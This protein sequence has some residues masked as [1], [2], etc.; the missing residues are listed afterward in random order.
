[1]TTKFGTKGQRSSCFG[2]ALW[3]PNLVGRTPKRSE[4][5]CWL[6]LIFELNVWNMYVCM[7]FVVLWGIKLKRGMGVGDGPTKFESIFSKRHH[8]RAKVIQGSSCL[9]NVLWPP[10]LMGNTLG[11]SVMHC[12]GQSSWRGQPGSTRGQIVQECP[13]ATK[14]GRKNPWPKC[15][16]GV[17]G[18][19]GVNWGQAEVK[20]LRN[21]LWLPDLTG[22]IIDRS[23][24]H[25]CGQRSCRSQLGS[26]RGQIA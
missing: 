5:Q 26:S 11:Q 10:N 9:R 15:I 1:M 17:E 19:V 13:M 7:R 23:V 25:C 16:D 8:Q 24:M 3:P 2:N 12:W 14:F 21:L 18:H 22:R 20:F 4:V 6:I